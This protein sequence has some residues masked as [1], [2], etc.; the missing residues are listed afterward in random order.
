MPKA[1][2]LTDAQGGRS[3]VSG[4][5]NEFRRGIWWFAIA[6]CLALGEVEKKSCC[7]MWCYPFVSD[8]G[9]Y[10]VGTETVERKQFS[11]SAGAAAF[12]NGDLAVDR[13]VLGCVMVIVSMSRI[14]AAGAAV[15]F[16][17]GGRERD[18]CYC[19]RKATAFCACGRTIQQ[20]L[21]FLS[22]ATGLA[23]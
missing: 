5:L 22:T 8:K 17:R 19:F 7:V 16:F 6:G 1:A 12:Q 11:F 13:V 20:H 10:F 2:F 15:S 23:A 14:G 9:D 21:P 4:D 18:G 3:L